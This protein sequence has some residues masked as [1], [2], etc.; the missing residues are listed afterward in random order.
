MGR[1]T[2]VSPWEAC[3]WV[4]SCLKLPLAHSS[5]PALRRVHAE[6]RS[7]SPAVPTLTEMGGPQGQGMGCWGRYSSGSGVGVNGQP[8]APRWGESSERGSP[9]HGVPTPFQAEQLSFYL[10]L[11]RA[12]PP[13]PPGCRT[14]L[15]RYRGTSAVEG[16]VGLQEPHSVA[17]P[18]L[19]PPL[20]PGSLSLGLALTACVI[21]HT[22]ARWC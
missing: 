16:S 8:S 18:P 11:N 13:W 22:A 9:F 15:L 12:R 4:P 20:R 7:C 3:P 17:L 6:T 5:G 19:Q 10:A 1:L 2:R 21:C 14:S